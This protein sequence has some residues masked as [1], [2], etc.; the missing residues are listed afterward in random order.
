MSKATPS[1]TA[2]KPFLCNYTKE[3]LQQLYVAWGCDK[4]ARIPT[5]NRVTIIAF[6]PGAQYNTARISRAAQKSTYGKP[7]FEVILYNGEQP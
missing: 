1:T 7:M 3:Q 5:K 6:P 2:A 4:I